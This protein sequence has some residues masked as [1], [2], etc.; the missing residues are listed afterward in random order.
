MDNSNVKVFE[1]PISLGWTLLVVATLASMG[2]IYLDSFVM[3]PLIATAYIAALV[4][5][6]W[7][8]DNERRKF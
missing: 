7:S 4:R 8:A 6:V 1:F 2:A 5:A 3:T